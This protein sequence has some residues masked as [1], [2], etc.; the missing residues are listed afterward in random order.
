MNILVMACV[1]AGP[2]L[3][4]GATRWRWLGFLAGLAAGVVY[5][6]LLYR[7]T[8]GT[9]RSVVSALVDSAQPCFVTYVLAFAGAGTLISRAIGRAVEARRAGDRWDPVVD[10]DLHEVGPDDPTQRPGER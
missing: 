9:G 10:E 3:L 4:L 8:P 7:G 6:V 2:A 5:I 1:A